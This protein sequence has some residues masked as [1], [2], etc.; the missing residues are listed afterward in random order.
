M[1]L[2]IHVPGTPPNPN[3]RMGYMDLWRRRKEFKQWTYLAAKAALAESGHA[4]DYPLGRAELEATFL[5][6]TARRR[7]PDNLVASLKPLIDGL[8][9]AGVLADDDTGTLTLRPIRVELAHLPG[10]RLVVFERPK[11]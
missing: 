7:D 3:Q 9:A 6:K 8:V 11:P 5:V 2:V 4:D 10:V 1:S